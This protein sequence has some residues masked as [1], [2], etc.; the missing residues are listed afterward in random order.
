MWLWIGEK[1]KVSGLHRCTKAVMWSRNFKFLLTYNHMK[2]FKYLLVPFCKFQ[3]ERYNYALSAVCII[4]QSLPLPFK[5]HMCYRHTQGH[6]YTVVAYTIHPTRHTSTQSSRYVPQYGLITFVSR[7]QH[8]WSRYAS[9]FGK[10]VWTLL[11]ST[12]GT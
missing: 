4:L 8:V 7:Y 2:I 1:F 12:E 6:L 9:R 5:W 10:P 3:L 11:I